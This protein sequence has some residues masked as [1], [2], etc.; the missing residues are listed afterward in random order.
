MS[1]DFYY[2]ISVSTDRFTVGKTLAYTSIQFINTKG[3]IAARGS[4]TKYVDEVQ[5]QKPRHYWFT[6]S[7]YVSQAWKHPENIV[8]E[9]SPRP[10]KWVP[11]KE[12]FFLGVLQYKHGAHPAPCIVHGWK[13]AFNKKKSYLYKAK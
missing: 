8:E 6:F 10:K 11:E 7:R 12:I 5:I 9:L 2:L 3:E 4:H 13:V 1:V